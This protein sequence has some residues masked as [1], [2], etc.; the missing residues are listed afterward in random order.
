MKVL[1]GLVPCGV[2]EGKSETV[3]DSC[4]NAKNNH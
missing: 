1:V 2:S 3:K 4:N